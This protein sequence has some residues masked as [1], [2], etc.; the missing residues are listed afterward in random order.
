MIIHTPVLLEE[1]LNLLSP[2]ANAFMIDGTLGEGG[3]SEAFLTRFG[4]LQICGIDADKEIIKTA[5]L[6]LEKFG[7]RVQFYNGWCEDYFAHLLS[8]EHY[9]DNAKHLPLES[10]PEY[11]EGIDSISVEAGAQKAGIILLDLGVS[12]YHYE[13][14]DRGFSFAKDEA[15]DMRIDP[16]AGESAAD[17]LARI[18]EDDLAKLL[19]NNAEER[20]SRR[21]AAAITAARKSGFITSSLQLAAIV[22]GACHTYAHRG[23]KKRGGQQHHIHPATKT[24]AALRIAVNGELDR[25]ENRLQLA[26][27]ALAPGGRLGV[28]TFHSLEDRIVKNYFRGVCGVSEPIKNKYKNKPNSQNSPINKREFTYKIIT[29]KAV[30]CSREESLRNHPS[31]S[32]KLRVIE[33]IWS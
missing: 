23:G 10:M 20:N 32:A 3:H 29:K 27:A 26:L 11:V 9:G 5:K 6:R 31:R 15:L 21:I 28:I 1:T 22:E 24:F 25:L 2:Q 18:G 13:K 8:A 30:Q 14:G 16:A 7:R 4:D 17:L 19:Y 12:L 33:K